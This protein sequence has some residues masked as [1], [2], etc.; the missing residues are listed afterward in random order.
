MNTYNPFRLDAPSMLLI[1][2]WNQTA[3]TG[4]AVTAGFTTKNGGESEPPLHSLNTGLHVQDH[5]Q[6]VINNRKKVAD[7]LKT[8]LHDWVFAD[9]THEDRIHKVTDGDRASGA[10]R[11]DT[12]L[13]A[14]DGLYTDRPNLFLA[15]CFADCVPVYFYDPVRSLVGIAHAGWKGTALGIAASMVDTWIRREGSNPADIRAVI[16][17]AI[18][19]CCY[20]VDDHVIDKIRNLPLQQEDKA[21]LTIKEG[22]YRLEL[23]EVNR[24]LLVHA[25]IPNGQIEVSS[26]CT[27]CER[28]LFFSHRRDRGKTGR[29]MSF[30]GLKEV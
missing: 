15:L 26:L 28:S 13:K 29:M 19:S 21:F 5:E 4:G 17:P 20:T 1:E 12:A 18:G 30:I 10:F 11:Y 7:I 24:Q 14:T 8:D 2:E 27:S 9:Q 6:H 22:E 3:E 25:G 23:K 16:G